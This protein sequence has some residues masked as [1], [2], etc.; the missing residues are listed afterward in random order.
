MKVT[1]NIPDQLILEVKQYSHG[2]NITES[3]LIALKEWVNLQHIT[4]LNKEI[5]NKPLQFLDDFN[6]IEVRKTN[7]K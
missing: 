1:A 2:K 5:S 4:Q 6:A 3:L 7:R